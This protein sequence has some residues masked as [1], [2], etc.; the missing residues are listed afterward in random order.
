MRQRTDYKYPTQISMIFES[1][2]VKKMFD[3]ANVASSLD[4]KLARISYAKVPIEQIPKYLGNDC[5]M[6]GLQPNILILLSEP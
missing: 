5:F 1:D 4:V 6:R 2:G 3:N